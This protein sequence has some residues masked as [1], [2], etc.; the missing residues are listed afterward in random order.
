MTRKIIKYFK[1]PAHENERTIKRKS[2][3]WKDEDLMHI[4]FNSIDFVGDDKRAYD[5]DA[6]AKL[7]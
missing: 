4:M 1:I 2:A 5:E 7:M 3:L 6:V